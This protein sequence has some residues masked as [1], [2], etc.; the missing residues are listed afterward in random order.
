MTRRQSERVLRLHPENAHYFLWRGRPTV[1]IG[2]GE[3]YG[4]VLN[5]DFDFERYFAELGRHGLNHTRTFSGIY[6]EVP[7]SFGITRNTLAPRPNR[8]ICPWARSDEPG[9]Y[10]GGNK[11]DLTRWDA[12]Y[13]RRLKRFMRAAERHGVIVEFNLFCPFYKDDMWLACPMN[14]RNNVNG[15]GACPRDE[16]Y[17]LQHR[18]LT[19]VQ[20][21]VTRKLV[22]ELNEFGNFYFEVCNEPYAGTVTERWQQTIVD[23]IVAEESRLPQ[24]HL[25]S[26]N[27][28]NGRKR[29]VCPPHH[30]SIF[31]FHYCVPPDTVGLNYHL[32]RPIG[33]N[34]TGFRGKADILYRTE[35]W[36]FMLSGGALYSNLDYSFVAGHEDGS[37][38]DYA[39][40]GGGSPALRQQLGVLKRFMDALD[41]V[42]L[43][44]L[45][46]AIVQVRPGLNAYLMGNPGTSYAGY[47]HVPLPFRPKKLQTHLRRNIR[48]EV[49]L[50]LAPGRYRLQWVNVLDG[51]RLGQTRL[52]ADPAG[53]RL[54]SP[55]FDN[56]IAFRLDRIR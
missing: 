18:D 52:D 13:F 34:E 1:L 16:V 46:E 44:P 56:D 50:A 48:A 51:S 14:A 55:P 36:A 39:S 5:L 37:F 40:P 27:V 38:L 33:E 15:I 9:Y 8:Y 25:I 2:S 21:A 7:S 11:F 24:Q 30:V 42:H 10:D 17:T 22:R 49:W 32:D 3:H 20:K 45:P 53:T 4:A 6:R 12:R 26:V 29:I 35:G 23:T 41:L 47:L 43:R 28:A 19:E 31:N 54:E